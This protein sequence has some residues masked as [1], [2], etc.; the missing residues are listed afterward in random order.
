MSGFG[1]QDSIIV[2]KM[3]PVIA[4]GYKFGQKVA[5][6]VDKLDKVAE[7]A[8]KN[9]P[10]PTTAKVISPVFNLVMNMLQKSKL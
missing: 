9:K 4:A 10:L 7:K 3:D 2:S 5:K 1:K 8:P 6:Y